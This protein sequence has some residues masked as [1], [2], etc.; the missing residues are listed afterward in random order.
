MWQR[1]LDSL[2][3]LANHYR[4]LDSLYQLALIN[5]KGDLDSRT[6][7]ANH[8]WDLDSLYQLAVMDEKGTLIVLFPANHHYALGNCL[9]FCSHNFQ[10]SL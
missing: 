1:D 10:L 4:D 3:I 8:C 6:I 7:P 5:E 2:T 9:D